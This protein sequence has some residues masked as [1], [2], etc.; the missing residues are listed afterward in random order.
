LKGL[1][2]D[3]AQGYYFSKPV[4]ASVIDNLLTKR[5]WAVGDYR[6]GT[7]DISA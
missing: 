1:A 2:C 5:D 6:D 7:A 4:P 3:Q